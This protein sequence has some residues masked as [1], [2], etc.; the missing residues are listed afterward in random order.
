M[1]Y[2]FTD[3]EQF[4]I[5]FTWLIQHVEVQNKIYVASYTVRVPN[6]SM[7]NILSEISLCGACQGQGPP[8]LSI[9]FLF[10]C[11]HFKR[12]WGCERFTNLCM[13]Y[14]NASLYLYMN[15]F[16]I[17]LFMSSLVIIIWWQALLWWHARWWPLLTHQIQ[18]MPQELDFVPASTVF[19]SMCLPK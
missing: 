8:E 15:C 4:T 3:Y 13:Y 7:L 18:W 12:G 10:K 9:C 6:A 11:N 14:L 17:L 16:V 1:R 2:L 5:L 19:T